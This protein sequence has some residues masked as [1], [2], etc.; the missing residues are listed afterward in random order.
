[1]RPIRAGWLLLAICAA[2]VCLF[3]GLSG[4]GLVGPDEPR[5]ASIARE[6]AAS[7]DWVT[8]RL[9][10]KPWLEK[11]I[12]YYWAAA[13]T[14][15][16]VG[17]S[18]I[19]ARLPSALSAMLASLALGWFGW[20]LYGATTAAVVLV[21]FPTTV[22]ATALGRGASPDMLFAASLTFTMVAAGRLVL[23]PPDSNRIWRV[24]FGATL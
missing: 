3:D 24:V 19:A 20:R 6:M 14:Y 2:Y 9:H 18:E 10:G 11:P 17:D 7:D 23:I 4:I 5:Y 12:L 16:L 1:M 22:A 8:P 21:L 13:S 15:W